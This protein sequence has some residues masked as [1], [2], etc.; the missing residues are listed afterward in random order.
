MRTTV[1]NPFHSVP[2]DSDSTE[3]CASLQMSIKS[4]SRVLP[5]L[6][7]RRSQSNN[8]SWWRQGCKSNSFCQSLWGTG[9]MNCCSCPP[10]FVV[11]QDLAVRKRLMASAELRMRSSVMPGFAFTRS[12]SSPS[13]PKVVPLSIQSNRKHDTQWTYVHVARRTLKY[14]WPGRPFFSILGGAGKSFLLNSSSP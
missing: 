13:M 6:H 3:S 14:Y 4:C 12:Q 1:S 7:R 9:S 5:L 10:V 2:P 11:V 8:S